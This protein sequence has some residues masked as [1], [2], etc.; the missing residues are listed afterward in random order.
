MPPSI[1]ASERL[2]GGIDDDGSRP[3]EDLAHLGA[4][5]LAQLVV[6][7][8]QRLVE[9]QQAGVLDQRPSDGGALLLAAAQLGRAG[10]SARPSICS[11]AAVSRTWRSIRLLRLPASRSGEAMFS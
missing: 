5:L 1:S 6:E 10:A 7:V 4:Q 11:I 3:P 9:Q 8:G 2:G